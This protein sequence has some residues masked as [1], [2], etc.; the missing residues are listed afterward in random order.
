M[1]ERSGA[2]RRGDTHRPAGP[3][4]AGGVPRRRLRAFAAVVVLCLGALGGYLVLQR[5]QDDAAAAAAAE[6]EAGRDRLEVADVLAVPHLVVRNTEAGPSFGKIAL[7]PLDDPSG[8]RAIMDVSCS[9]VYSTPAGTICLQE[10]T[11]LVTTYQAVFLDAR[12]RP[13]GTQPLGGVPSR[14]RMSADGDW[15]ASTVFVAGHSYADAQF[16][17]ETV[18]TDVATHRSLGSLETWT[19]LRDGVEVT[20][21][22]RNYWGVSFI[23]AGPQFYA[24]LGTAGRRYLV[25]GDAAARTMTVLATQG[26]CPSVSPDGTSVVYKEQDPESHNDHFVAMDAAGATT[27][28]QEGRLVDD[29]VAWADEDTVLYAVGKGV[30]SSVDFDVWSAPVDGGAAT[31]LVADATSPSMVR[32]PVGQLQ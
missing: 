22:D 14:A 25:R 7:V 23:G 11:G 2:G 18:I 9:R 28:L 13:T 24:T 21:Q 4:G 31:V 16:S 3:D 29:Q 15:A 8:P 27:P 5:H 12:L 26:A 19:T 10:V 1:A 6:A 20:A 30:S 32:P 17:T